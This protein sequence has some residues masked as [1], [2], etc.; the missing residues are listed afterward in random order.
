MN[1]F[2]NFERSLNQKSPLPNLF[3]GTD[4]INIF[5][6]EAMQNKLGRCAYTH[7]GFHISISQSVCQVVAHPATLGLYYETFYSCNCCRISISQS[8]CHFRSN[9]IFSVFSGKAG[10]YRLWDSTLMVFSQVCLKILD[11]GVREWKWQ[12]LQL[13]TIRQ[14]LR[15]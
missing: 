11:Q 6:N 12:T 15:L 8:G 4:S 14:Q 5:T 1:N 13:I 10:A 7:I 2:F 9:R 3:W